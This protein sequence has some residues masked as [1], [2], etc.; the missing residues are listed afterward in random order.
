M[1]RP[2][3]VATEPAAPKSTSSGWAVTTRIRSTS[4]VPSSTV[5]GSAVDRARVRSSGVAGGCRTGRRRRWP[6]RPARSR[7]ALR[8]RRLRPSRASRRPGRPAGGRWRTSRRSASACRCGSGCARSRGSG[9]TGPATR[10]GRPSRPGRC[11]PSGAGR[12]CGPRAGRSGSTTSTA[13]MWR[14]AGGHVGGHQHVE[15]ALGEVLEGAL[16]VGLAQVA[17]DGAGPHALLAQLLD[18]AVGSRAWCAR[19]PGPCRRCGRWRRTP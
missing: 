18:Q 1:P 14:P 2:V 7:R 17:V 16:P 10:P 12:P 13:S 6:G 15:L 9:S 11:G 5:M 4:S 3:Q 8:V 19:R